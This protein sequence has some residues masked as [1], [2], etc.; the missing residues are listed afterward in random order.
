MGRPSKY[1]EERAR[2]ICEDL[3]KGASRRDASEHNGIDED[4]LVRWVHRFTGFAGQVREAEA[5]C[6]TAM[7]ELVTVHAMT[8][9]KYA[10]EWLKRRRRAE[11]GDNV[12]IDV[13]N[14]IAGLLADLAAS[15]QTEAPE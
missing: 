8:D 12:A 15:G 13:D 6:A 1:T 11:W 4:T 5:D 14:R 2:G 10:V 3:R 9:A 7:S